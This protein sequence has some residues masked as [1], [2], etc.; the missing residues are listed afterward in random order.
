M[1]NPV[2]HFAIHQ[3]KFPTEPWVLPAGGAVMTTK[4][5]ESTKQDYMKTKAIKRE[6]QRNPPMKITLFSVSE[7]M[8]RFMWSRMEKRKH[9]I[10]SIE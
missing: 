10:R 3:L 2:L 1:K 6:N 5:M 7:R 8:E 9:P 4:P